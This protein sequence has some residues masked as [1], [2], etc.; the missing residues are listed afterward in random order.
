MTNQNISRKGNTECPFGANK[1]QR[2]TPTSIYFNK[3]RTRSFQ[4]QT[5][6]IHLCGLHLAVLRALHED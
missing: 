2:T 6:V 1:I 4:M 3:S 5:L